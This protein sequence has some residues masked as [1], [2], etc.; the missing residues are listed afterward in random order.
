[1]H[2]IRHGERLV[3]G[4]DAQDDRHFLTERGYYK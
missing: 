1:M 4:Y 3:Y 2:G